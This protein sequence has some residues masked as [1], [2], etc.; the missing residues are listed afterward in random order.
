MQPRSI[1]PALLVV[2]VGLVIAAWVSVG[3]LFFGI[4]GELT[5]L[6]TFTLGL[7]IV[8]L[9]AFITEAL[10]RTAQLGHRTR[11]ATVAMLV[12]SWACG[13]LLGLMIPDVTALGLQTILTGPDEPGLSIAIGV[14][15]PLGIIMLLTGIIALVLARG[16]AKGKAVIARED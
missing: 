8:V 10:A 13:I 11:P 3:R 5:Q 14:A 16:D 15:N 7:I 1:I 4:A 12:A 2:F 9:H 6:Y